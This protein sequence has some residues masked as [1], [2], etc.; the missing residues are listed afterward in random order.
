MLRIIDDL[1][2]WTLFHNHTT[3]HEHNMVGHIARKRHLVRNNNHGHVLFGQL[4]NNAQHL[5]RQFR[6]KRAGRLVEEQNVGLH[7]Q[8]A[9]NS[10]TLLL[11]T[12]KLARHHVL[13]S[14]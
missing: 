8:R 4:A 14:R 1:G 13:F 11:A 2:R 12:G 6:V 3:I 10:N 7:S 5:L 9:R